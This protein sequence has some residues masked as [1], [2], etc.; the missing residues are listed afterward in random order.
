MKNI[1]LTLIA[2]VGSYVAQSQT[3]QYKVITI[4]ESFDTFGQ[5][6]S[7][8]YE[9]GEYIDPAQSSKDLNADEVVKAP[10]GKEGEERGREATRDAG[11]DSRDAAKDPGREL[12]RPGAPTK[13]DE[14][15]AKRVKKFTET[16]LNN[17]GISGFNTISGHAVSSNDVIISAKMN[18]MAKEGWTLSHMSTAMEGAGKDRIMVTRMVFIKIKK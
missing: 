14:K 2:V 15:S 8:I 7:G 17:L 5:G 9:S 11:R 4:I 3:S 16:G 12:S 18:Q 10:G 13:A 1:A 6:K